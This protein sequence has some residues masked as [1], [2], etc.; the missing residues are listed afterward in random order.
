M[1]LVTEHWEWDGFWQARRRGRSPGLPGHLTRGEPHVDEHQRRCEVEV[2]PG[3]CVAWTA[4]E[5]HCENVA[6]GLSCR[7]HSDDFA[8]TEAR[9]TRLTPEDIAYIESF[10]KEERDKI[11]NRV[12]MKRARED[13]E[14]HAKQLDRRRAMRRAGIWKS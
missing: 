12:S 3:Y 4:S 14:Y 8:P 9:R 2:R 5:G 7:K 13:P 1:S 6:E 10:P 11:R